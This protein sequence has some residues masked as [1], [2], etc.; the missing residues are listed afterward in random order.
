MSEKIELV[1]VKR[2]ISKRE[3]AKRLGCSPSNLYNKMKRDNFSEK[4]LLQIAYVL[5]CSLDASFVL[6]DT[7][8]KY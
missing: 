4:E 8:E 6:N 3:L 2:K 5:N 1:L 7:H